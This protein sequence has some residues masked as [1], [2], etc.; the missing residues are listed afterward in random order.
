MIVSKILKKFSL[1]NKVA[2]VTGGSVQIGSQTIEIL[3]DTA[4]TFVSIDY[5]K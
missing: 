3:L 2:I 1:K 4:T 5:L